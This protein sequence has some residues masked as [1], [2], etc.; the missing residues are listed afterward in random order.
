MKHSQDSRSDRK[1]RHIRFADDTTV[2]EVERASPRR[3]QRPDSQR[4]D[5]RH[6]TR[7]LSPRKTR[8]PTASAH[9]VTDASRSQHKHHSNKSKHNSR[10]SHGSKDR[11]HHK[12]HR[13]D[14]VSNLSFES[15]ASLDSLPQPPTLHFHSPAGTHSRLHDVSTL[16]TSD[17]PR[18][19]KRHSK[20]RNDVTF[21]DDAVLASKLDSLERLLTR[22]K[23]VAILRR[24][25]ERE[26]SSACSDDDVTTSPV[27]GAHA[28]VL[29]RF[30]AELKSLNAHLLRPA[31]RER[32]RRTQSKIDDSA[33]SVESHNETNLSMSAQPLNDIYNDQDFDYDPDSI[34]LDL[35]ADSTHSSNE[36]RA[37]AERKR[38]CDAKPRWG[39]VAD[40]GIPVFLAAL[41]DVYATC[42]CIV[43]FV[44]RYVYMH[45]WLCLWF[46]F[47]IHS[48][49][50]E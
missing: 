5:E 44:Y 49:D 17:S 10:H 50:E 47:V 14:D 22:F 4:R 21:T 15:R 39:S 34:A 28:Q 27:A 31:R 16:T 46:N 9:D 20:R 41:S 6:R 36:K 26:R 19:K 30:E 48:Y 29:A 2:T 13:S 32:K 42:T 7:S 1:T 24:K 11:K 33:R 43:I 35:R 3:Q 23:A 40:M 18:H 12:H 38:Q 37:S 25:L 8:E 45:M